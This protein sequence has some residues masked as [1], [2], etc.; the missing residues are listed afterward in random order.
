MLCRLFLNPSKLG[1]RGDLS[2][3]Q[4]LDVLVHENI[5]L[6]RRGGHHFEGQITLAHLSCLVLGH[7]D[8]KLV[9]FFLHGQTVKLTSNT[10]V[11][12]DF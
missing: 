7:H 5:G 10:F 2:Q 12:G 11:Y 9:Y 4:D 3:E 1:H 6:R 8:L